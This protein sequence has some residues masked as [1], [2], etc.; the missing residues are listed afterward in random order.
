MLRGH[1]PQPLR[2]GRGAGRGP[3]LR[4][5]APRTPVRR[6]HVR[7]P[8]LLH[9]RDLDLGAIDQWVR[10]SRLHRGVPS[11]H[12][13]RGR[14][15]TPAARPVGPARAAGTSPGRDSRVHPAVLPQARRHLG[16]GPPGACAD[17]AARLGQSSATWSIRRHSSRASSRRPLT[18]PSSAR[19]RSRR[20]PVEAVIVIAAGYSDEV[21]R[22]IR[23]TFSPDLER[24]HLGRVGAG[25]RLT[26][27]SRRTHR[28][29]RVGHRRSPQG[30]P[31]EVFRLVTSLTPMTNVDLLIQNDRRET[32][33]TWRD[34]ELYQ[35]WHLPGGIV[36]YK[37]RMADRWRRWRASKPARRS[38][39]G[40]GPV[41]VNEVITSTGRSA[42][43][44]SRSCS[45]ATWPAAPDESRRQTGP[46]EARRVG[47]ARRCP[48]QISSQHEMYRSLIEQK[49]Q[50]A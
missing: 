19:R 1:S 47:V 9:G 4:H 14:Q 46:A 40:A 6:V 32:L 38:G 25:A 37:E 22:I 17:V 42:A 5:D 21:A 3:E 27:A 26:D 31:D 33:P 20:D 11:L 50:D 24:R 2:A 29:H 10:G 7:S 28:R 23:S 39:S 49:L 43:T 35:G 12:P 8:V 15:E 18:F 30:L 34:D 16:C 44:S 13:V 41:A 45:P 48:P 36:R